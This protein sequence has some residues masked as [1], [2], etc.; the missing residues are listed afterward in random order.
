MRLKNILKADGDK[1]FDLSI[2]SFR[3]RLL[4]HDNLVGGCKNLIDALWYEGFIFD[5]SEKY[6]TNPKIEQSK[7]GTKI[8]DECIVITRKLKIEWGEIANGN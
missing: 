4:D 3:K 2:I 8:I 6:I 5:D 7:I 1:R